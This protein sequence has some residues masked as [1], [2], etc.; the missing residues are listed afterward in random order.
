MIDRT[1]FAHH[2]LLYRS[3]IRPRC[4]TRCSE[5]ATIPDGFSSRWDFTMRVLLLSIAALLVSAPL[6]PAV[7]PAKPN[8]VVIL[9]D[10]LGYGDVKCFNPSGK[11]PTPNI[12]RL[13]AAGMMFTDANSP[14]GVC[15]P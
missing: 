13:A 10:D 5:R 3:P 11:I 7:E 15:S 14:S 1:A 9:C 12:D 8:I 6:A 4:L 2:L